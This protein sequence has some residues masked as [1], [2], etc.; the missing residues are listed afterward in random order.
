MHPVIQVWACTISG[1]PSFK[2]SRLNIIA[3]VSLPVPEFEASN[4]GRL[5]WPFV[6]NGPLPSIKAHLRLVSSRGNQGGLVA[7]LVTFVPLFDGFSRG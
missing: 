7:K 5:F 6:I 2:L 1:L 3:K 4:W